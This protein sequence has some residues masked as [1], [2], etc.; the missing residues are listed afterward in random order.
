MGKPGREYPGRRQGHEERRLDNLC[1]L[2][3]QYLRPDMQVLDVGCGPGTIAID[4][5]NEVN[6]GAVVGLDPKADRVARAKEL[7]VMA[8]VDNISFHVGDSLALAFAADRFDLVYSTH[9]L[10]WIAPVAQALAE[11]R[12]VVRRGGWVVACVMDISATSFYPPCPA[13]EAIYRGWARL[14]ELPADQGFLN[15]G[16]GRQAYSLFRQA[17]FAAVEIQHYT[18][19]IFTA[20][21]DDNP[22][23]AA[24][25]AYRR[26]KQHTGLENKRVKD[27]L[28]L[29]VVDRDMP[30]RAQEELDRWLAAPF[31][32]FSC[33]IGV[34]A[35]GRV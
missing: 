21:A 15:P 29:G 14:N 33:G 24:E 7:A 26:A 18:S 22:L 25:L 13:A 6:P 9:V 12:R 2:L 28:K 11:Q 20:L 1:P 34:L 10:E 17:G 23:M 16:V 4:V 5:A 30:A 27:L 31:P 32:F 19:P 8:G 3:G 35:A